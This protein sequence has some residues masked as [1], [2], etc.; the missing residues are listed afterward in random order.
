M[1]VLVYFLPGAITGDITLPAVTF[2]AVT[3]N[4]LHAE[5]GEATRIASFD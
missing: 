2:G 4:G 3:L 1:T 5:V